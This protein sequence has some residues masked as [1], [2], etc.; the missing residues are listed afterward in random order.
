MGKNK[1]TPIKED[2]MH[3][4]ADGLVIIQTASQ[5]CPASP[6]WWGELVLLSQHLRRQGILAS[7]T[8]GVR[9]ARR[10]V[11]RYEVIDFLVVLFGYAGSSEHTL[12]AFYAWIAPFAPVFM[13]LFGRDRLP[14]R[15]ALS[16]FLKAFS[17]AATEALRRLFLA[18]LL[19]RQ[20]STDKQTGELLDR[21]GVSRLVFDLDG[22]RE[23]ARQRALPQS[24]QLPPPFRRLEELCAPGYT[25]RKRGQI[26]RTRTTAYQA[27]SHQW[28][29]TWGNPGN[30]HY[31]E[32][33]RRA[34]EA[35][36]SYLLAHQLPPN[37]AL[38]RLDGQYGSGAVVASL[39]GFS[40]VT[41]GQD[42]HLLDRD[43]VQT[44]LHLPADASFSRPENALVRT[45]SDCPQVALGPEG[46]CC[47]VVVATHPAPE[48]RRKRHSGHSRRGLVY[49]LFLTNLP[50]DG[51]TAADVVALDLQRGAFE[52]ALSDEDAA[53]DPARW[54][55]QAPAGQEAW[56]ILS[57]WVW[58]LRLELGHVLEPGELRTTEFAPAVSQTPTVSPPEQGSGPPVVGGP[59]KAGRFVGKDFAPQ[60]DGSVRCPAGKRLWCSE[61][62]PEAAGLLRLVYEAR[63]ADCRACPKREQCQWH[64]KDARHPR[65]VSLLLHPLHVGA[66]PL[67]WK[68]WPR[69][70]HRRASRQLVRRERVEVKMGDPLQPPA[71]SAPPILTRA[72]RAHSRLSFAER[73]ARNARAK[74]AGPIS[75]TLFGVP[76]HFAAFLGLQAA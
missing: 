44:R 12:E 16:R 1:T 9:F 6:P 68:D 2:H 49:E 15:S 39:A 58:N 69:R 73:L 22:T 57:Q 3:R 76:E 7:L 46:I 62:R 55:S 23:A 11:G 42:Y 41:R 5:S 65:W 66:A 60:P 45:L 37:R 25:G 21:C 51:F 74:S 75:L 72:R 38:L 18:D 30:G 10:R 71:S 29:G 53:L 33:L 28:L 59:W 31:R 47:R 26:V 52:N 14:S 36:K 4:I 20:L 32:E 50:Q 19:A 70:E 54:C 34:V 8:E 63:I 64:G 17:W 43:E 61:R 27:H 24:E 56:Q 48:R 67:L 40:F 13:A 35:V